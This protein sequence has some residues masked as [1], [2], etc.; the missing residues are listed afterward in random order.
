MCTQVDSY[1][2]TQKCPPS[3]SNETLVRAYGVQKKL[4]VWN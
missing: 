4:L 2:G 3:I 1:D